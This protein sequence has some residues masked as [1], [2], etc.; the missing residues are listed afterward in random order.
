M[1]YKINPTLKEALNGNYKFN[2][3]SYISRGFD[4][5]GR[6][7]MGYIGFTILYIILAVVVSTIPVIG[8]YVNTLFVSPPLLVG[9]YIIAHNISFNKGF[10]FE[11]FFDG[12]NDIG[13]LALAALIQLALVTIIFFP[14]DYF[15]GFDATTWAESIIESPE[16]ID[17]Q[18]L[19]ASFSIGIFLLMIPFI[20]LTIAWMFAPLFIIFYK[21]PAWEAMETS[22]KLITK[23]W[24][25]FFGFTIVLALIIL[26]GLLLICVGVLYFWP[27]TMNALYVAFE[28]ITK[29]YEEEG[30]PDILDHLVED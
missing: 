16:E 17:L 21:M 9:Y 15:M 26:A 12:F 8:D 29:F 2:F 11:Q 18:T 28:D 25:T 30:E 24:F 10:Q 27:G 5:T 4:I 20:Y 1:N 13:Q 22:R 7:T 6:Y 19:L 23:K 3:E 14:M